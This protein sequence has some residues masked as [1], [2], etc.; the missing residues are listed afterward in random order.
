MLIMSCKTQKEAS[1]VQIKDSLRIH[2][3]VRIKDTIITVPGDTIR[4]E[5]PCDKDTVYILKSASKKSTALVQVHNGKVQV[6]N[7]CDEKDII[8]EKQRVE[9]EKYQLAQRDSSSHKTTIEEVKYTPWYFKYP[10]YLGWAT[11]I[12]LLGRISLKI[13]KK[14]FI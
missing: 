12:F 5:V 3:L 1:I 4:Y 7:Y 13:M 8:I 9:L 14:S 6:T 11:I 10:G 2:D